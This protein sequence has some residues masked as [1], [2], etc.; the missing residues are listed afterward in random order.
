MSDHTA[1]AFRLGFGGNVNNA[2]CG[3]WYDMLCLLRNISRTNL[4]SPNQ[5]GIFHRS[6]D[7]FVSLV[8]RLSMVVRKGAFGHSENCP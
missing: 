6:A 7:F 8:F 1:G 3:D 5:T 4:Y 2:M